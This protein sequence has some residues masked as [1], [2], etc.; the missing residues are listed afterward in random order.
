MTSI[1]YKPRGGFIFFM[2]VLGLI[3]SATMSLLPA[4]A[5][6]AGD[7]GPAAT[8]I[9]IAPRS[10]V[11]FD[12]QQLVALY[13]GGR[14]FV[15]IESFADGRPTRGAELEALVNFLPETLTEIAPGTYQ[16]EPVSLSA[17]RTDIEL[18]W[19]IGERDGTVPVVLQI[20]G[21]LGSASELTAMPAPKIPG[22]VFL[23]LAAALYAGVMMLFW[24]QVRNRQKPAETGI[25]TPHAAE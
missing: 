9:S 14:L 8:A 17:G 25:H 7:H 21:R 12:N 6:A 20:P 5:L 3:L 13:A 24:R 23:L 1:G 11:R 16:S 2:L 4:S 19:R 10:E 18:N 22:W 15:F